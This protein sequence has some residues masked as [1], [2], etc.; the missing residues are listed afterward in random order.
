M[1]L[2]KGD[3]DMTNLTLSPTSRLMRLLLPAIL[4]VFALVFLY[5]AVAQAGDCLYEV[6]GACLETTPDSNFDVLQRYFVV[7]HID[8]CQRIHNVWITAERP[9]IFDQVLQPVRSQNP[10]LQQYN[11]Q[12]SIRA[13]GEI[14]ERDLQ[15]TSNQGLVREISRI[16]ID[17][18]CNT[19]VVPDL[20]ARAS[21]IP[22][23]P[24]WRVEIW[25]T[26]VLTTYVQLQTLVP[27]DVPKNPPE[28]EQSLIPEGMAATFFLADQTN[29]QALIK[30][31]NLDEK[32]KI[33]QRFGGRHQSQGF[34]PLPG[35]PVPIDP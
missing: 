31:L 35:C 3:Q 7:E 23:A 18:Q 27:D 33:R 5:T 19:P 28:A 15:V 2:F 16:L 6:P 10:D 32:P 9:D 17:E 21:E 13:P 8:N 29:M 25:A 14:R 30:Y 4:A 20:T 11:N 12:F 26:D 24:P 22:N 1:L 34:A